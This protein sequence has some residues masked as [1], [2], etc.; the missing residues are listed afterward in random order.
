MIENLKVTSHVC[1]DPQ[2]E[3]LDEPPGGAALLLDTKL[4]V[5]EEKPRVL[6]LIRE[7]L[8]VDE[9]RHIDIKELIAL[10]SL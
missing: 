6:E 4:Q 2:H 1:F 8:T 3:F 9:S 10:G 5:P 7:G